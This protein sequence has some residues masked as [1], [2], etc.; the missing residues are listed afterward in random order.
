MKRFLS[1]LSAALLAAALSLPAAAQYSPSSD[2]MAQML[3]AVCSGAYEEGRAAAAKRAEKIA[4]MHLEY[5]PVDFDELWL[6][7]KIICAEAGS[8]WLPM[9]WKMAVGEVVLNRVAS[10]EFPGTMREV[11]E[12]P[13]QYYGKDNPY[14]DALIPSPVCAEAARRLLEGERVL[15]APSVVFQSNYILGS[16]VFLELRDELLGSTYL[17]FSS[18]PELYET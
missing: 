15:N 9:S 18:R 4:R 6:L 7:S 13:G 10:P 17:C 14:F 11:L 2:Y 16:G 8:V 3:S 12:Q 1:V 5:P